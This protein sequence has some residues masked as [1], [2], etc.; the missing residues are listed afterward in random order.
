MARMLEKEKR[1][2]DALF[3]YLLAYR[4]LLGAGGSEPPRYVSK[5]IDRCLIKSGIKNISHI[6]LYELV[7]REKDPIKI[8]ALVGKSLTENEFNRS[9]NQGGNQGVGP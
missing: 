5:G 2:K 8:Q 3:Q 9:G 4:E 7:K 6:D 1:Y